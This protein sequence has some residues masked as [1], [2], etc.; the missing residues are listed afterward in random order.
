MAASTLTKNGLASHIT[1]TFITATLV[2]TA[3]LSSTYIAA[4]DKEDGYLPN[5]DYL[6]CKQQSSE[7]ICQKQ[8]PR[9]FRQI[10][11]SKYLQVR[12]DRN[13]NICLDLSKLI[14]AQP[15]VRLE[16]I[17]GTLHTHLFD[18]GPERPKAKQEFHLHRDNVS[19]ASGHG[20]SVQAKPEFTQ[21]W[22]QTAPKE[23]TELIEGIWVSYKHGDWIEPH[24]FW[25]R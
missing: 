18:S 17:V 7:T 22:L 11:P 5:K 24:Q 10:I 9:Y 14:K 20:F 3:L 2:A 13:N 21:Q 4:H 23:R 15:H 12:T 6:A 19:C 8:Y 1:T 16:S 25:R